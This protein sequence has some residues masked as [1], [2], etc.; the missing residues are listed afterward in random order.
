M[1]G[2]QDLPLF[3]IAGLLLNFTPGPDSLLVM[4]RSAVQGWRAGSAAAFGI[5]AG[6]FVHIFAA[7]LGLSALLATSSL[8]FAVVKYAGA[9]YLLY[10]GLTLLFGKHSKGQPAENSVARLP[11]RQIFLQ[12]FLTNV[13]NPKVALFFLAFVPQFIAPHSPDKAAAFVLLGVIFNTTGTAW[14]H[15]LALLTAFASRK[16]RVSDRIGEWLNRAIGAVFVS[17]GIRL[18]LSQRAA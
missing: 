16:L 8:A 13:L 12:G 9:A 18:A 3:I 11:L 2:I 15:V 10:M 4:S 6:T 5:C 1:F 17:F 7:A 14:C